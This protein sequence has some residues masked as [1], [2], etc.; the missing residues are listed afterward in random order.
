MSKSLKQKIVSSLLAISLA[1]SLAPIGQ[2]KADS[3]SEVPQTP[4]ITKQ[5]D[6]NRAI[7]HVRFLSETI[8]IDPV[9]QNPKNGLLVTLVCSLN[10]WVMT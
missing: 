4:S 9:E 6:P 7:E 1:V 3:T 8:G 10:Q 2:A 5:I